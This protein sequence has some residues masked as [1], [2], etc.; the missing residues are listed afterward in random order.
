MKKLIAVLLLFPIAADAATRI[1]P[2]INRS[3]GTITN[4]TSTNVGV[5]T[6]ITSTV[7]NVATSGSSARI[8]NQNWSKEYYVGK[9]GSSGFI[10]IYPA[11]SNKGI[12][13]LNVADQVG[14]TIAN[15]QMGQ[16]AAGRTYTIPDA[17]GTANFMM[18]GTAIG[19]QLASQTLAELNAKVPTAAGQVFYCSN[20]ATDA[21]CVSTGTGTGAFVRMSARGTAC[22]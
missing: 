21:V 12:F 20:C 8:W 11:T 17:G 1:T 19:A 22:Q 4:L 15:V 13:R 3:S 10:D 2:G 5:V 16:Q 18:S 14:N 9:N 7:D 6:S